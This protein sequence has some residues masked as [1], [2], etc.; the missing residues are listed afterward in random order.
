MT[1]N[2]E[3]SGYKGNGNHQKSENTARECKL[4]WIRLNCSER[5]SVTEI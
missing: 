1:R 3:E 4:K 2:T 5:R